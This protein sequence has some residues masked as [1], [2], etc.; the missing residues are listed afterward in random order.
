M[1]RK[2]RKYFLKLLNKLAD[3]SIKEEL[4]PHSVDTNKVEEKVKEEKKPQNNEN[5]NSLSIRSYL[6]QNVVPV[7]LQ[8]MAEVAKERPE[9]PIEFL[10]NY[11][12]KHS[13]E[14]K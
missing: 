13:N 12:L 10:A 5:L 9:N 1:V 8:G 14:N 7:L 3:K 2:K 6:D 4:D 11:L